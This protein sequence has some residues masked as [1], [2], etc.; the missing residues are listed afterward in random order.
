MRLRVFAMIT[1]RRRLA[2]VNPGY[3][4][5]REKNPDAQQGGRMHDA[6]FFSEKGHIEHTT[7]RAARSRF[8]TKSFMDLR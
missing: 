1:G 8:N 3:E 2:G 7:P 5:R 4:P 6:P